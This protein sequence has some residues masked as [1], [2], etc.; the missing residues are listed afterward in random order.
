[1]LLIRDPVQRNSALAVRAFNVEVAKIAGLV[2]DEKIGLMRLQFWHN[3]IKAIFANAKVSPATDTNSN[4]SGAPPPAAVAVPDHPVCRAVLRAVRQH[5]LQPLHFTRLIR[6]RER[7]SNQLFV[8]T[9]ALEKY[10]EESTSCTLYLLAAVLGVQSV[11]VDHAL[12]HLGKAHGIVNLLRAQ[13]LPGARQFGV[14][15]FPQRL[16]L[17]QG[18][19]QERLLRCTRDDAAVRECTYEVASVAHRHLE[20]ARNLAAKIPSGAGRQL[21]LPALAVERYL[22]RLQRADFHLAD[23]ALRRRDAMLPMVYYW[24]NW[25]GEY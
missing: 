20:K 1:M 5:R 7:P 9:A 4:N 22:T 17:E 12:S 25:R 6:A 2:S 24:N 3:A 14:C 15:V 16:Q 19:S 11:D 10:A 21:L 23:E 8:D 13:A 18:V